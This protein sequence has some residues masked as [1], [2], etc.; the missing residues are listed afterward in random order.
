MLEVGSSGTPPDPAASPGEVRTP[1]NCINNYEYG[2]YEM[3]TSPAPQPGHPAAKSVTR[4][5]VGGR[6]WEDGTPY[7]RGKTA[8]TEAVWNDDNRI[9]TGGAVI[10]TTVT[11]FGA[12]VVDG[13]AVGTSG[14]KGTKEAGS[15]A[16]GSFGHPPEVADDTVVGTSH[17]A[18]L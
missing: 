14:A 17:T 10:S 9:V 12:D 8:V 2:N 6:V 3:T 16:V 11:T 1:D 15:S 5:L 7:L 4:S 18:R 13:P